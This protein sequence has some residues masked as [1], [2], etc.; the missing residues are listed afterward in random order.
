MRRGVEMSDG[1]SGGRAE[2]SGT[3]AFARE[4]SGKVRQYTHT[5]SRALEAICMRNMS[6]ETGRDEW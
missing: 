1:W 5:L 6:A 2:M 3:R 4:T